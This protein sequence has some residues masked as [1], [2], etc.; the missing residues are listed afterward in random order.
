MPDPSLRWRHFLVPKSGHAA[1][2]CEDAVAGDPIV[3]R[4]AIADGASESY[5][6]GDWARLLVSA[7]VKRGPVDDW[8][9]EP[10]NEWQKA[11]AGGAVSWYA[12]EKF[13][14]GGHATFLGVSFRMTSAGI[15]WDAIAAGDACLLYIREGACVLSFPLSRSSEFNTSPVLVQSRGGAP[16][17]NWTC[18]SL[19]A[20]ECLLMATDALAQCLLASAESE[21][22]A[23][24]ALTRF[25]EE[26]DL[27]LWVSVWRDAGLLRNDDVAL[28]IIELAEDRP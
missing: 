20:G 11:T 10:R 27:A 14:L 23:G 6:A 3:G 7:F 22:F 4:F 17:W 2:E 25:E 18:G 8:L 19:K 12:E 24:A 16:A 9:D 15:A 26:D 5:A 21:S 1:D 13:T 28:G